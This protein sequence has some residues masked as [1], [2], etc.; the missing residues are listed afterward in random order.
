MWVLY[1]LEQQVEVRK[2]ATHRW[3]KTDDKWNCKTKLNKN[4]VLRV[5]SVIKIQIKN[6]FCLVYAQCEK[7]GFFGAE[8][9]GT[10]DSVKVK[11]IW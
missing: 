1:N 10:C 8:R 7:V 5:Q 11:F 2:H 4:F 3:S 9:G 6:L